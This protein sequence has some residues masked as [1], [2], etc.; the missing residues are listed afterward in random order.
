MTGTVVSWKD[1]EGWGFL[2]EENTRTDYF[3]HYSE[4]ISSEDHKTLRVGDK[5]DFEVE[6][7]PKQKPQAVRLT[8]F[9]KAEE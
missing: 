6:I 2:R 7:G 3:I 4:V 8:V 9:Q 1:K 5:V